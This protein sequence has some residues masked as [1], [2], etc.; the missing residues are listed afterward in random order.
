MTD[1]ASSHAIIHNLII[2]ATKLTCHV[3]FHGQVDVHTN[4]VGHGID[5]LVHVH[6]LRSSQLRISIL[7]LACHIWR[8]E[9]DN[10]YD[11]SQQC[12]GRRTHHFS[13]SWDLSQAWAWQSP[14]LVQYSLWWLHW[15]QDLSPRLPS[16]VWQQMDCK[17]MDQDFGSVQIV[18]LFH[19]D[20]WL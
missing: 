19:S 3:E 10:F 1:Y 5:G 2:F 8:S 7:F 12:H 17:Q 20:T 15:F 4:V 18:S 13:S 14:F 9:S 16:F 11:L 6:D